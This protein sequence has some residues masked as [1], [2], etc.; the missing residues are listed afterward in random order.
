[1]Y[2]III[3]D[4]EP[5]ECRALEQLIARGTDRCRV[6]QSVYNGEELVAAVRAKRP[7]IVIVDI[8]MPGLTGLDAI[9]ILR[10][11]YRELKIIVNT[12][13]SEFD[14]IKQA[15]K[16][17]VVNYVLKP[18]KREELYGTLKIICD[19]LDDER[20][21][22][23][24]NL[25]FGKMEGEH[26][27]DSLLLEE[28]DMQ[29]FALLQAERKTQYAGG[30]CL[31]VKSC[32]GED[33]KQAEWLTG[34]LWERLGKEAC[35][36]TKYHRNGMYCLI[37]VS[38]FAEDFTG[39]F[40]EMLREMAGHLPDDAE[41][42]QIGVSTWKD[43]PEEFAQAVLE[44]RAVLQGKREP[45]LWFCSGQRSAGADETEKI[46]AVVN[47]TYEKRGWVEAA[48]VFLREMQ[49]GRER[50]SFPV[51]KIGGIVCLMK[52]ILRENHKN[53][54][55]C[56]DRQMQWA[57]WV[58][59]RNREELC[60]GA[61]ALPELF[62]EEAA[63]EGNNYVRMAKEYMEKQYMEDVS[64]DMVA[65][66]VGITSFY[67]S[68]LLRRET[69]ANFTEMLTDIRMQKALE[70]LWKNEC[71]IREVSERTGYVSLSYFYKVFKK[72]FGV[73]AGEILVLLE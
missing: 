65:D 54:G 16:Y 25:R 70:L 61:S 69:G 51:F 26:F 37:L 73:T 62:Q 30:I 45:G 22:A 19:E 42:I 31:Y 11:E 3:A 49:S 21:F 46:F 41:E 17:Q 55:W 9:A 27:M 56:G 71:S 59:A 58:E 12:A 18:V 7:D 68:R 63:R 38:A 10:E 50:L 67:M 33:R 4:D 28:P 15:M 60:A 39:G 36:L 47:S 34:H 5:M 29:S 44:C 14:Y 32:A 48:V 66:H 13:Y 6:I 52:L 40:S 1:M 8:Q 57:K 35:L 43:A 64:L 24:K 23:E 53:A 2:R 20:R 72:Y